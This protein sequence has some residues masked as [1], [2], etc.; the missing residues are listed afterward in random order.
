MKADK[1][2]VWLIVIGV[3][4]RIFLTA[5]L[6]HTDTKNIY[7]EAGFINEGWRRAYSAAVSAGRPIYYPPLVYSLVEGYKKVGAPLFSSY[8]P[9]WLSDG[10]ALSTD[11]HPH[12]F[13]DLF[14]MKLPLLLAD[15]LVA[16]LLYLCVSEKN[17][18]KAVWLWLFNPLTL[19]AIYGFGNY[20]VLPTGLLVTSILL[21][22]KQKWSLAYAA[23]GLAAGLKLFALLLLPILFFADKRPARVRFAGFLIGL[24]TFGVSTAPAF[25]DPVVFKSIFLSNLS[26]S[27]F[28]THLELTTG[29]FL[30]LFISGYFLLLLYLWRKQSIELVAGYLLVLGS[31]LSISYFNPQW[32]IWL[33]PLVVLVVAES[34]WNIPAPLFIIAG[35]FLAVL[36][37]NDKFVSFGMLKGLNNAFDSLDP[38][39]L[40]LA[41]FGAEATL[42]GL[43]R[44][45]FFA[46]TVYVLAG[47]YF[48]KKES[49]FLVPRPIVTG[50][51]MLLTIVS[52][53]VG[54][55]FLLAKE[56]RYIAVSRTRVIPKLTLTDKTVITQK[57]KVEQKNVVGL[58]F[59]VKN[60][61]MRTKENLALK[62][63]NADGTE[64][65]DV[66]VDSRLIG[67]D[68]DLLIKFP[69]IADPKG[70]LSLTVSMPTATEGEELFLPYDEDI[71]DGLLF[72]DG[73]PIRGSLAYTV[74][75]NPGG[76]KENLTFSLKRMA[77][78][79]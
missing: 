31:L 12:I 72:V 8:F 50:G 71:E 26:G 18:R 76:I 9:K 52:L 63:A 43:G 68:F 60:F 25:F 1:G 10:T 39:Y 38:I 7:I 5:F 2:L 17:R 33:V 15:L 19:Y 16:F 79:W 69:P 44:A 78:K 3:A 22:R 61:V 57:I 65:R 6:F 58:D 51:A 4:V 48:G 27:L 64:V 34:G 70:E 30:P 59:R 36:L 21:S 49:E 53:F 45:L 11:N 40:R 55:H 47:S 56:G 54:A 29:V 42:S 13:R 28:R 35:Y 41:R 67:D 66:G 74:Y 75:Y 62:I 73:K 32:I 46:G 37:I 24:L 14:A 23:L 20:D 77:S